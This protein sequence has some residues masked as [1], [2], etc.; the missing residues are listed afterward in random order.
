MNASNPGTRMC[1]GANAT[2]AKAHAMV[3]SNGGSWCC[4]AKGKKLYRTAVLSLADPHVFDFV[5]RREPLDK[6]KK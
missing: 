1:E 5:S 3:E 6:K 4:Q 2:P